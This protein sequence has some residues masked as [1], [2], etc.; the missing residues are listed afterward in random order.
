GGISLL[1]YACVT[2]STFWVKDYVRRDRV[3][4][5]YA[6]SRFALVSDTDRLVNSNDGSY[7]LNRPSIEEELSGISIPDPDRTVAVFHCPPHATGID[8][9]HNSKPIGSHS[10]R[11]FLERT[12]P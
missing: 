8:T 4:D 5:T 7:A 1:G 9:L 10:I 2:D 6:P 11:S 3:A 12:Q